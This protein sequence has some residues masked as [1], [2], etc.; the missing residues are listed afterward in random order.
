[1]LMEILENVDHDIAKNYNVEY[2]EEP[3]FA[4]EEMQELVSIVEKHISTD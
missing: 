1:M 2:A 3:E 4:E